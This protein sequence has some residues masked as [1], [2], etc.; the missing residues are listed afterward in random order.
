MK[1]IV[2]IEKALHELSQ[3]SGEEKYKQELKKLQGMD[4][5]FRGLEEQHGATYSRILAFEERLKVLKQQW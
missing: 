2:D 1:S 5:R 4:L 3:Q